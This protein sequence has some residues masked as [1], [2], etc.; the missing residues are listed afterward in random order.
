M[1]ILILDLQYY[2]FFNNLKNNYQLL[3]SLI[4]QVINIEN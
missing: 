3:N 4:F 1:Y 2:R